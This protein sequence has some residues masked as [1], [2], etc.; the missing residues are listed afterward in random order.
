MKNIQVNGGVATASKAMA[1]ICESFQALGNNNGVKFGRDFPSFLESARNQEAVKNALLE[2]YVYDKAND[3]YDIHGQELRGMAQLMENITKEILN[4]STSVGA[5]SPQV[6][7]SFPLQYVNWIRNTMKHAINTIVPT[8][9]EIVRQIKNRYVTNKAGERFLIQDLTP[10]QMK[11]ISGES[12]IPVKEKHAIATTKNVN[13]ITTA[14]GF[15]GKDSLSIEFYVTGVDIKSTTDTFDGEVTVG[16]DHKVA[17]TQRISRTLNKSGAVPVTVKLKNGTILGEVLVMVDFRTGSFT[18]LPNVTTTV[19]GV[20]FENIY[21]RGYV[22]AESN[23]HS[24]S[25]EWDTSDHSVSIPEGRHFNTTVTNEQL[26][27]VQLF[28]NVDQTKEVTEQMIDAIEI[29]KDN[30]I[31]NFLDE[32][33]EE[34]KGEKLAGPYVQFSLTPRGNYAL[35][36]VT[37]RSINFKDQIGRM[38]AEMS[39]VLNCPGIYSIVGNKT[40]IT[41]LKDV[42]WVWNEGVEK[43]G[44]ITDDSFGVYDQDGNTFKITVS[45]RIPDNVIRMYFIP[46]DETKMTFTF[47]QYSTYITN[48]YQNPNNNL[49]PNIMVSDR[50]VTDKIFNVQGR[51]E[52]VG[53]TEIFKNA[54]I[55]EI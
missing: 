50:Y 46:Q 18:V 39:K 11:A 41:L 13:L 29:F 1:T 45:N 3:A 38:A 5:I 54:P 27:D 21:I 51:M 10:A 4:E 24:I 26:T 33:Y 22:S 40:T 31:L 55:V 6:P 15:A 34:V 37:W 28:Y 23:L 9:T 25:V 2:T 7:L 36:P 19:T 8:S 47:Y 48:K 49:I 44:V 20:T 42:N 53:V 35:D 52:V 30:D 32:T 16:V 43:G 12:R 14:G 17:M